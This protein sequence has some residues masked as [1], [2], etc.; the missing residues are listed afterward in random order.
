M[1][2]QDGTHLGRTDESEVRAQV[3]KEAASRLTLVSQVREGANTAADVM[4]QLEMLRTERGLPLIMGFDNGPENV[5]AELAAYLADQ[6]V[7]V[8]YNV[9]RTPVAISRAPLR[10]VGCMASLAGAILHHRTYKASPRAHPSPGRLSRTTIADHG[11]ICA[12]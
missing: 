2:C 10:R 12:V 4:A 3:G 11:L 9:P 5:A 7:V 8:L 1:W 6:Q